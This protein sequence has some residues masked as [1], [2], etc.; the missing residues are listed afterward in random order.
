MSCST[1][2]LNP[3]FKCKFDKTLI[4]E[5]HLGNHNKTPGQHLDERLD[6]TIDESEHFRLNQSLVFRI[7]E[8]KILK[9]NL[10]VGSIEMIKH[11]EALINEEYKKIDYFLKIYKNLLIQNKYTVSDKLDIDCILTREY[12][13]EDLELCTWTSLKLKFLNLCVP[14]T[15]FRSSIRLE[16]KK[17]EKFRNSLSLNLKQEAIRRLNIE[18]CDENWIMGKNVKQ[19]YESNNGKFIFVCKNYS[20]IF[21][22]RLD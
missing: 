20:G 15:E 19:I 5:S 6:L 2:Q 14:A 3:S 8:L 10:Q 22:H 18:G 12:S 17:S 13:L 9:K 16:E 1:C 11:I 21:K 4:C 7:N